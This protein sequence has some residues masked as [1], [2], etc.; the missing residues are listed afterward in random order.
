MAPPAAAASE[1]DSSSGTVQLLLRNIDSTTTVIRVRREDTLE[2]V[3]IG[4]LGKGAARGGELPVSY[5]GR[6]LPR[7]STVGELGVPRDATIH[8]SSRLRSTPYAD[9]WS[10]ASEI[11]ASA[12][13]PVARSGQPA[14]VAPPVDL[15]NLVGSFL[16]LAHAANRKEA[17]SSRGAAVAAHLD[18]FL[19]SGA[20]VVLV[21]QYLYADEPPR[22]AEAERAIRRFVS[23]HR[24]V[25]GWTAPVLLE[26]CRSIAAA[27]GRQVDGN[28][29]YTDLRGTL[30]AVLSDP[31]W[32]P[33]RW[34]D[35]P[36]ERVAEQVG[37]FAGE[38]ARAVTEEI[39]RAYCRS[40]AGPWNLAAVEF[41]IFWS[42]LRKLDADAPLLQ[43]R[44]AMF[45]TLAS[46]LRSV[47]ECMARF[48]KSLPRPPWGEHAASPS[49]P[50]NWTTSLRT[51]WAVLA[52]LDAWSQSHQDAFWVLR[53]ALRATLAEHPAAVTA[54]VLSAGREMRR[55]SSSWIARHRDLLPFEARRHLAMR[56]LPELVAGVHAPPPYE[57]LIDRSRLLPDSFG[58]IAHATPQELG[59]G[60]SVAFKHEQATG[61]GM[62]RE[63]FCLV[64]QA[65]FNRHLVLFS[66][67]PHDRRRFFINPTSAVDPLHLEY[68]EIAGRMIA[69]ALMHKI[70]VGVFFDRT[71]FLRLTGRSITLDDIVDADPSLHKSCK[72]ILEMDQSLVDSNVLGLTF[73]REVEVLGSRTI[74]ELIPSGKDIVVT[75]QNRDNYISLLIQDR[76]IN[77]TRRQLSYFIIGFSSF[78]DRG[79]LGAKFFES[80]DATDFD[81]MLGGGC[82]DTID[83]KE[84]RAYTDYRGYKE[85]DRQIKW[86]WEAVENMTVEQ[87]R[88]LLFF[89]TSVKYLPSD[90][91]SGLGCR[92][93]IYRASSSRD[94]LPTSQT[95]FYHL[96][97]P[98]YTSSRMMQSRLRMIVQEHMSSGFGVS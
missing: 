89:W 92:L 40:T 97:L 77:S 91:F 74:R 65:L 98:A 27:C 88:M 43:C 67:C 38:V 36:Q 19:R 52:E 6:D 84:W 10:L 44:T 8:V 50:P 7:G 28:P 61:P 83:V 90:G 96:N 31:D 60:L 41:K 57:M 49:A 86:F 75:S 11:A 71:L 95:C 18:I 13:F 48:D 54:L 81:R 39:A 21:Q 35:L 68:F 94:H 34:L 46:L 5:A 62:L 56:M 58:Y 69:L 87:Q 70:H 3:L 85:K 79:E 4:C 17:P 76:F 16:D 64:S 30:A 53:R 63:W 22:H 29:L 66:A 55:N 32:T 26:F 80:L 20:P 59:A 9:A 78:F 33:A 47:D 37:R 1:R 51:V 93:F 82:N 42:V 12:R 24:T 25:R 45:E 73:V 14:V 72:Q 2:S 15:D 23:P